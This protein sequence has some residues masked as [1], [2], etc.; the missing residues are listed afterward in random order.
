MQHH[1]MRSMRLV[2]IM[3]G[4]WEFMDSR[5]ITLIEMIVGGA[6]GL[7][8]MV[9]ASKVFVQIAQVERAMHHAAHFHQIITQIGS[10]ST[11]A[12]TAYM[13]YI[14]SI[15]GGDSGFGDNE[16][17]CTHL[18][19][20]GIE[21]AP[22]GTPGSEFPYTLK[23]FTTGEALTF[24]GNR[25]VEVGDPANYKAGDAQ[26]IELIQMTP[27]LSNHPK[28]I[29]TV[30]RIVTAPLKYAPWHTYDIP[31]VW[32][33]DGDTPP[34]APPNRTMKCESARM[35]IDLKAMCDSMGKVWDGEYYSCN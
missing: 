4:A 20:I 17:P 7:A 22:L 5:G 21:E 2:V 27:R 35:G 14:T 6:I 1:S 32:Q 33:L 31:F 11:T 26:I 28:Y 10:I 15:N 24:H 23:T 30:L 19:L 29:F 3:W 8:G 34:V 13:K 18:N 12:S 9:V 16:H 25:M